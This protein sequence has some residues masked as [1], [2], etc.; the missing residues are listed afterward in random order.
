MF[1]KLKQLRELKKM[2]GEMQKQRYEGESRGT[3]LV[4]NGTLMATE[5]FLNA[6]LGVK[7]QEEAV[8]NAFNDAVKKA[9]MA[10]A[11]QFSGLM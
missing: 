7:E 8:R 3:K 6:E 9:Q 1:D 2:Q 4:L 5:V 10:M 11:Q